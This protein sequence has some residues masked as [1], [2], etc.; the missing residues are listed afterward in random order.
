[1]LRNGWT[2]SPEYALVAFVKVFEIMALDDALDVLDLLIT[3]IAGSAKNI[4]QKKRLRTLKDLDKSALT[5]A[6]VRA[7]IL[8]EDKQNQ[9]LADNIFSRFPKEK[10]A[11]AV[12]IINDLARPEDDCYHE[13]MV[14]QYDRVRRFLPRLFNQIEFRSAPA[15]TITIAVLDYLSKFGISRKH[16]FENPPL[17]IV[18]KPWKRLVVDN[19]NRVIKQGYTLCFLD[20]L[21]DNLRRRDIYVKN[22]ERW[23]DPR[24]KLFQ[25][26]DWEAKR[27][28]VCQSLGHP[29]TFQDAITNLTLQLDAT[30]KKVSENFDKNNLVR[31][32]HFGKHPSLTIT[33]LNKLDVPPSLTLLSKKVVNLLPPVDRT[34]LLLEIH[35]QTGFANEFTHVSESSARADD[36]PISLCAVL[37]AEA[38]NIGLKSLV[39]HN[40]PALT[41]HRL[42]WVK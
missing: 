34:D 15:G 4:G 35:A 27:T 26:A 33:N 3:D 5:L 25:G 2:D 16:T 40:I 30:Y 36:L 19:K 37:L 23:G 29:V 18:T 31:I 20:K 13:E 11:E 39:K 32:D 8:S 12:A 10:L 6:E 21:Q 42:S 38:C 1:M 28:P 24:S 9:Q 14:E 17:E 22:S 41:R 7:F